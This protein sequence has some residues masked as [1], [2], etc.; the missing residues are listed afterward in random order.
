MALPQDGAEI[1]C[2]NH[3]M[4]N[5]MEK[6]TNLVI[7]IPVKLRDLSRQKAKEEGRTLSAQIRYLLSEFIKK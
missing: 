4:L 3:I 7:R 1:K 2:L 6:E 5:N